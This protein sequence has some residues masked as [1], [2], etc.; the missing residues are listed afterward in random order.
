MSPSLK[1]RRLSLVAA[2]PGGAFKP[3]V[4]PVPPTKIGKFLA[5]TNYYLVDAKPLLNAL[6]EAMIK[7]QL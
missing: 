2:T 4:N 7:Q 6:N 3:Y 5:N 1:Q